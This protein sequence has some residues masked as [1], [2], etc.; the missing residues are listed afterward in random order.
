ME[1]RRS[2]YCWKDLRLD[3]AEG[4]ESVHGWMCLTYPSRCY[5]GLTIRERTFPT[6]EPSSL[7]AEH[8]HCD[9]HAATDP[10]AW[11]VQDAATCL[12]W[13]SSKRAFRRRSNWSSEERPQLRKN[14]R[15]RPVRPLRHLTTPR[16]SAYT[17]DGGPKRWQGNTCVPLCCSFAPRLSAR[18]AEWS[19]V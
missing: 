10:V 5:S 13:L 6:S 9:S 18:S 2:V 3:S 7:H 16:P 4:W 8:A 1:S 17:C 14:D 15:Q 19:N 11:R 12:R